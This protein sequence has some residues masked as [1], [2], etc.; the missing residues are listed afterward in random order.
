MGNMCGGDATSTVQGKLGAPTSGG[1][2][3]PLHPTLMRKPD[4]APGDKDA[5]WR[6]LL[7]SNDVLITSVHPHKLGK[8]RSG[9][10]GH[11]AARPVKSAANEHADAEHAQEADEDEYDEEDENKWQCNGVVCLK[12]GCKSGQLGFDYHAGTEGWQCP[13]RDNCDFDLCSMCIRWV[14]HCEKNKIELEWTE[15]GHD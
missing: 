15:P 11:E 6:H 5:A 13:D 2:S 7:L 8:F 4:E 3:A 9:E 1:P 10:E 14:I 12:G